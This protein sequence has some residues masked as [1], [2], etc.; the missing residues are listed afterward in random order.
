M[1][2]GRGAFPDIKDCRWLAWDNRPYPNDEGI[3][4]G[5]NGYVNLSFNGPALHIA[6]YDLHQTR[7][8][9]EDW[10]VDLESGALKGP[11]L[12]K[13]LNDAALHFREK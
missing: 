8:M 5:Y 12:K 10:H 7:L 2:V 1:P 4:V 6:Y 3:D 11:G 13:D 9:T